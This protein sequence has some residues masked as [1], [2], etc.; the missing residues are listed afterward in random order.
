VSLD[1][2]GY[3]R[4]DKYRSARSLL[5]DLI[6]IVSKNGDMLLNIGPR[7]NGT[8]PGKVRHILLQM[9][10]WLKVNGQAIY[11]TRPW[12]LYGEGPTQ[13]PSGRDNGQRYTAEDFRFTQK[14]GIL[15]ALGMARP[16]DGKALV[17]TLYRATPYLSGP[18]TRVVLL[19]DPQPITW[20]QTHQGLS[21][22][23]PP[24][25]SAMPYVLKILTGPTTARSGHAEVPRAAR[26]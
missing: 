18:I 20:R 10:A 8:I 12:V 4:D 11:G 2:W 9:G 23:L 13:A 21:V 3:V 22:T 19:G 15:Y 17:E 24:T 16:R 7:A 14:Q 25:R 26:G 1:S 6:D 5:T